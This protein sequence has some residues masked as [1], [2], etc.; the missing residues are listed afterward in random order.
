MR[1]SPCRKRGV[2]ACASRT[3]VFG[4]AG[5]CAFWPPAF[6]GAGACGRLAGPNRYTH[7]MILWMR[8]REQPGVPLNETPKNEARQ[9]SD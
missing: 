2:D 5:A 1:M 3:S 6:A 9:P 4:R 8:F 7:C